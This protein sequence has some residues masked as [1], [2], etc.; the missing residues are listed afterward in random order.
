MTGRLKKGLVHIY[1][2]NG[3]G[4]TT[5]AIGLGVRAFGGGLKVCLYQFLKGEGVSCG[6]AKATARLGSRF[7]IVP[8]SQP[9]PYFQPPAER[10]RVREGLKK[11]IQAAL[12]DIKKTMAS[13]R[14]DL[15]IL[16]ELITAIRDGFIDL[17][18]VL[19]LIKSKPKDTEIVLTGRGAPRGLI[20]RADYVSEMRN[21]KHPYEKGI[22][23]RRGVEF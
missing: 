17:G 11:L 23:A 22:K 1:T 9:H 21:I 10:K 4:K 14:Y 7:K 8:L 15:I 2:G 6:E 5:A 16:D 18:S 12:K 20:K 19:E 3:K 13:K